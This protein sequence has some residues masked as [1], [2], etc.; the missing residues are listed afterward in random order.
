ME[1]PTESQQERP[2]D[3]SESHDRSLNADTTAE[4]D[5]KTAGQ[6]HINEKWEWTQQWI[7]I[8]SVS[9]T[10]LACLILITCGVIYHTP[11]M[12]WP[13]LL[14]MT[15]NTAQILTSYFTRTNHTAQG[16]VGG[17]DKKDSR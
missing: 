16:G 15:T 14:F 12:I 3:S 7:A 4:Q 8:I 11:E 6:R 10:N 9:T 17:S 2:Q 5:R 13:A 1:S